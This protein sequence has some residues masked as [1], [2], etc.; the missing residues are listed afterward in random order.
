M[1][2]ELDKKIYPIG[3]ANYTEFTKN[4]LYNSIILIELAPHRLRKVLESISEQ[5]LELKY[6]EGGWTIRQI[7]H[8]LADTHMNLFIRFKLA[9]TEENPTIKPF[10][11]NLWA[12]T[13]D[14]HSASIE[15]SMLLFEAIQ[16][17]M[18]AL[19]KVMGENDFKKT[20]YRADTK[21]EITLSHLTQTYAWHG[22]HHVSQ[23]EGIFK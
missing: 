19:L 22:L 2:T 23:I 15:S 4:V 1:E 12:Q 7:V 5:D 18:L 16:Q 21:T 14:N 6:R 10:D 11:V 13:P 20:Y 3:K 8:H 9:L 17:R